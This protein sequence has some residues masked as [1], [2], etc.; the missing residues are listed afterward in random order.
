MTVKNETMLR[1]LP[2]WSKQ[3]HLL[4]PLKEMSHCKSAATWDSFGHKGAFF[5]GELH[6]TE[7]KLGLLSVIIIG[8]SRGRARRAPLPPP[9]GSRFFRFDMQNFRNVATSGVHGPPTGNPGSATDNE[10]VKVFKGQQKY[11]I[12]S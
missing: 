1:A 3:N 11:P 2:C 5:L 4:C 9:H 8:G 6:Y 10:C 12:V 7:S